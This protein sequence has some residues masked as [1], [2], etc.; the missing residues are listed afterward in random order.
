VVSIL[1]LHGQFDAQA[2]EHTAVTLQLLVPFMVALGGINVVKKAY[3]ALDDRTTL[4]LVG[5][6]GLAI[7]GVSGYLLSVRMGVEGLGLALS[8]SGTAQLIAYVGILRAKMGS[9]LGLAVLSPPLLKRLA[10]ALPATGAAVW[11][12]TYGLW[13]RGPTILRNWIVLA[14]AG[15][16]AV[17]IY[18]ALTWVLKVSLVRDLATR[19]GATRRN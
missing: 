15:L 8:I 9:K 11:L 2:V 12:C 13:D 5:L 17:A 7:T 14:A 4:L 16:L 19:V 10:A 1:F 6:L 18:F 3:F